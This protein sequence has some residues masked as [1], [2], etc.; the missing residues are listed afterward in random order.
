MNI[1]KPKKVRSKLFY[2]LGNFLGDLSK[3]VFEV[4]ATVTKEY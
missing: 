1:M 4:T 3:Q 2:T